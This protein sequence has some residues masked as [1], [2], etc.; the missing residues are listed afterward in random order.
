M[1]RPRGPFQTPNLAPIPLPRRKQKSL[2]QSLSHLLA[3]SRR[4]SLLRP[5]LSAHSGSRT[6]P[7]WR[8]RAPKRPRDEGTRRPSRGQRAT[9]ESCRPRPEGETRRMEPRGVRRRGVRTPAPK[10][11]IYRTESRLAPRP[12]PLGPSPTPVRSPAPAAAGISR[13]GGE[14]SSAPALPPDPTPPD[15]RPVE[16]S[17]LRPLPELRPPPGRWAGP[18]RGCPPRSLGG[19]GSGPQPGLASPAQDEGWNPH[20]S[21]ML[22]NPASGN[23]RV[24][25]P[26]PARGRILR[27]KVSLGPQRVGK[28]LWF[29]SQEK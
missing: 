29:G 20:S 6:G 11:R 19:G 14:Q 18:P 23:L 17:C 3:R 26:A 9:G 4:P 12:R 28:S 25:E 1:G 10:A 7:M 13:L 24:R 5:P 16:P 21:P 27:H 8:A 2:Q 15:P 22:P